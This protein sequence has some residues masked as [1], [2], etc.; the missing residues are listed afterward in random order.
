MLL[1]SLDRVGAG[2]REEH[3]KDPWHALHKQPTTPHSSGEAPVPQ[4]SSE[5]IK[6]TDVHKNIFYLHE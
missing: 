3:H 4:D 1:G 2:P 5:G 6:G